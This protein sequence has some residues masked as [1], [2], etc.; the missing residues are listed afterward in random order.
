MKVKDA[1]AEAVEVSV[2]FAVPKQ[3][4]KPNTGG[5]CGRKRESIS[6]IASS[7][8]KK[9]SCSS[10]LDDETPRIRIDF[11]IRTLQ[12]TDS[13]VHLVRVFVGD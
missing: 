8:S 2:L 12:N 1:A 3:H 6:A 9:W 4:R 5:L 11:I 10:A 7:K 13:A